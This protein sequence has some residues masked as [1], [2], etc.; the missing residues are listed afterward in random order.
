MTSARRTSVV[1]SPKSPGHGRATRA[2]KKIAAPTKRRSWSSVAS[3]ST[4]DGGCLR[5]APPRAASKVTKAPPK[6]DAPKPVSSA[7]GA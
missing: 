1:R 2:A 7:S 3:S 6:T 4:T 5:L